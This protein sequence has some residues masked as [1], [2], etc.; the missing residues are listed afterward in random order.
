MEGVVAN[1]QCEGINGAL[2]N[3]AAL[4]GWYAYQASSNLQG[5]SYIFALFR[6]RE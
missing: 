5:E 3:M 2:R 1:S 6:I 4:Q